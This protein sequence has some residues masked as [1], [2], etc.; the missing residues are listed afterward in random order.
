MSIVPF[1]KKMFKSAFSN[2]RIKNLY[3][4]KIRFYH[5]FEQNYIQVPT[6][7]RVFTNSLLQGRKTHS[8]LNNAN[9]P[10][11][12]FNVT[13]SEGRYFCENDF[14][15]LEPYSLCDGVAQCSEGADERA[16]LCERTECWEIDGTTRISYM[17]FQTHI[18]LTGHGQH[19]CSNQNEPTLVALAG[20]KW[21]NFKR[22]KCVYLKMAKLRERYDMF[23]LH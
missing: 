18:L 21:M 5:I 14:I 22:S 11:N 10:K 15:C 23:Q 19:Y 3:P 7:Y 20:V 12:F 6:F 4:K 16:K 2:F 9:K 8:F 13:C 17:F 1:S